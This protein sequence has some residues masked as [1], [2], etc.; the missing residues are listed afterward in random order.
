MD[1]LRTRMGE[2]LAQLAY[3]GFL[4]TGDERWKGYLD[5]GFL[6][7]AQEQGFVTGKPGKW[8]GPI[9]ELTVKGQ[10]KASVYSEE[11]REWERENALHPDY[12]EAKAELA[13]HLIYGNYDNNPSFGMI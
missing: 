9:F 1:E 8:T 10:L 3:T 4:D 11:I 6:D 7:E 5:A 2:F 13:E 12:H